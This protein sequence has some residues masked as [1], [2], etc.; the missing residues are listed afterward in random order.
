MSDDFLHIES[1]LGVGNTG[2]GEPQ[3]I[4]RSAP[5]PMVKVETPPL[6]DESIAKDL[7]H[8]YETVRKNL[9][10]LVDAGKNAL[11]G[12]MAV[13]QEGDSPRAYEVV[14][15]MIKTLSETNRD[16]L[17]LHDKIK[18]IRKNENNTTNN[19][20][21]NNSIYVGSTRDLQDIINSARSTTKAFIDSTNEDVQ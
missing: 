4:I 7:K 10:E 17:D 3:D 15:Q 16:L 13:A 14:A 1:V 18:G 21:T 11:D 12:V 5:M 20:T 6:T 9:R 19:H 2:S 8:D